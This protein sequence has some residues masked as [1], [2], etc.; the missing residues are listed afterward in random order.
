MQGDLE[1]VL[2]TSFG[3]ELGRIASMSF[4]PSGFG[5]AEI[6]LIDNSD[7]IAKEVHRDESRYMGGPY[8]EHIKDMLIL[9]QQIRVVLEQEYGI[10]LQARIRDLVSI[11]LHDVVEDDHGISELRDKLRA[12]KSNGGG[13]ESQDAG[14]F[15]ISVIKGQREKIVNRLHSEMLGSI[16]SLSS[17]GKDVSGLGLEAA[18]ALGAVDWLTRHTEDREYYQSVY[19]LCR[20]H[21]RGDYTE[22]LRGGPFQKEVMNALHVGAES[23]EPTDYFAMRVFFKLLD[24]VALAKERNPRFND[25]EARELEQACRQNVWL[26]TMYRE[27]VNFGAENM[28]GLYVMK[29][30]YR[31][32]IVL[33][34]VN[35]AL[36]E[37]GGRIAGE[38][39]KIPAAYAYLLGIVKAREMLLEEN[40]K[41]AAELRHR[42]ERYLGEEK[43][44]QIREEF[45]ALERQDPLQFEVITGRGP[46]SRGARYDSMPRRMLGEMNKTE[47]EEN[48][49]D[50]IGFEKLQQRFLDPAR[51][52]VDVS[53][54]AFRLFSIDGLTDKLSIV[55]TK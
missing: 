40:A 43:A 1:T 29:L 11:I 34:N 14:G 44:A 33:N 35:L 22:G 2:R 26:K 45:D 48:Y 6:A 49:K 55:A 15:V 25:E 53:S 5:A 47:V 23:L 38:K 10:R 7:R 54:G 52:Y 27:N 30:L 46:I 21:K 3:H 42:Y 16:R 36:N 9:Y 4:F 18:I 37:Y 51:N 39:E 13:A 17:D 41:M 19:H 32:Y 24:R 12:I 8:D 20:M 31:N 28:P 50:V